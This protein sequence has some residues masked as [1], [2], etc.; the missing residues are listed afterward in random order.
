[1]FTKLA[2]LTKCRS[3]Q[4]T[5][6][7]RKV[8]Q[9]GKTLLLLLCFANFEAIFRISRDFQEGRV[10]IDHWVFTLTAFLPTCTVT[11]TNYRPPTKLREGNV[12]GHVCH[13]V[14]GEQLPYDH[15]P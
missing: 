6:L 15:N 14:Q 11:V 13:S 12:F 3:T 5:Q 7:R 4:K 2:D 8:H 1:M 10:R 9:M